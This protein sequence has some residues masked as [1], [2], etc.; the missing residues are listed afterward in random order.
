MRKIALLALLALAAVPAAL[1]ADNPSP[2]TQ[3]SALCK[4]QRTA[5]GTKAFTLLY[6]GSSNAFGR[7]VSK[8][9][10]TVQNT[11]ANAA[12]QCAAERANATFPDTH[13]GKSFDEYYGT[14]P[15][16]NNAFGKCVSSKAQSLEQDQQ[17]STINAAKSCK[18]E[19]A[20]LGGA[21]FT[22]K[23]G[24]RSNAFGKCVAKK[25]ATH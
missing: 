12:K 15:H 8:V 9:A 14:G 13:D 23:Y 11:T 5:L 20:Q 2:S 3:A 19:R 18:T 21:A 16:G 1:A 10:G 6:G 22:K 24:G 17:T 7:C 25:Q 4:Q